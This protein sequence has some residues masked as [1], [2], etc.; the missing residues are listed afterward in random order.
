M[1]VEAQD[2]VLIEGPIA[3][4]LQDFNSRNSVQWKQNVDMFDV[5]IDSG[6]L[7]WFSNSGSIDLETED[8]SRFVYYTYLM[9]GE[10][11]NYSIKFRGST[12][13]SGNYWSSLVSQDLGLP[14]TD[15]TQE[16]D[17]YIRSFVEGTIRVNPTTKTSSF[18]TPETELPPIIIDGST[19][20]NTGGLDTKLDLKDTNIDGTY[21]TKSIILSTPAINSGLSETANVMVQIIPI[22]GIVM[23]VG[24]TTGKINIKVLLGFL[25]AIVFVV[26]FSNILI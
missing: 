23:A 25:V 6:K 17:E 20:P 21:E 12:F 24:A 19:K 9:V 22:F 16:G 8:I 14:L 15:M 10:S 7:V 1:I 4:T 26:L 13:M 2:G 18:V 5:L 3:W 11:S